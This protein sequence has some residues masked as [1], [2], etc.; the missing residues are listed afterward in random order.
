MTN[1]MFVEDE[2]D[3]GRA[4]RDDA[5]VLM[6]ELNSMLKTKKISM[7]SQSAKVI[8][9]AITD[10]LSEGGAKISKCDSCELYRWI[11][12]HPNDFWEVACHNPGCCPK[13]NLDLSILRQIS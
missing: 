4:K 10:L 11:S 7:K 12:N 8:V 3:A 9:K 13:K 5:K 6:T 2:F 1:Q